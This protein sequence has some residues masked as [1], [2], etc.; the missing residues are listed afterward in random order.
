MKKQYIHP[1]LATHSVI[2]E[3]MINNSP[4][5]YQGSGHGN[6]TPESKDHEPAPNSEDELNN[7]W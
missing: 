6:L 3:S 4:L 1:S 2:I 7:L 5:I